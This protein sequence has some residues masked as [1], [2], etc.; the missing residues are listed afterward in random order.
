MN[1]A[2]ESTHSEMAGWAWRSEGW[3]ASLSDDVESGDPWPLAC[4]AARRRVVKGRVAM[5]AV[6]S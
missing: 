3:R 6:G 5:I 1:T 4:S 2:R